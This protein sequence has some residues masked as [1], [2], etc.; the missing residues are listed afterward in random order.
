MGT[1]GTVLQIRLKYGGYSSELD[2]E[3]VLKLYL[4]GSEV[5]HVD[6][7]VWR[8]EMIILITYFYTVSNNI[9]TIW[10]RTGIKVTSCNGFRLC[11][12]TSS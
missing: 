11:V 4:K 5:S 7:S 1:V 2:S 3:I 10:A 12:L 9:R 6:D 8:R